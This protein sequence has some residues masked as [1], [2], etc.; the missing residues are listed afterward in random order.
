MKVRDESEWQGRLAEFAADPNPLAPLLRDFT[1]AWADHAES[2]LQS[3]HNEG[4]YVDDITAIEALRATLPRAEGGQGRVTIGMIGATF[5]LLSMHWEHGSSLADQMTPIERRL[6]EDTVMLK[7]AQL[8][9][10]AE[11]AGNS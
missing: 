3:A 6:L 4:I 9:E 8:Q 7:L 5:T 10:Q 2:W 11:E 1:I